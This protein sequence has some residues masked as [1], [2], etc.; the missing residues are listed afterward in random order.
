MKLLTLYLLIVGCALALRFGG[1]QKTIVEVSGNQQ[2]GVVYRVDAA[3]S[4][5]MV[6]AFRSGLLWFKGHDHFIKVGDFTGE[7][8]LTP[9]VINPATL[10]MTIRAD[11]LEETGAAFTPEQKQIIKKELTEI[12]LEPAKYPDIT[13]RST[14]VTG[15]FNGAQFEAKIGGDLGLHGVT[16]RV[17]IPVSVTLEGDNLRAKG[18]FHIKRGDFNVK[19]TSAV[20]GLVRVQQKLKF[21]FD[22]V[23]HKER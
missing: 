16:R 17:V 21:T 13:F 14:D 8:R 12:V 2:P 18:E 4:Q 10:T 20:H 9:N 22:I 1:W 3:Q 23:A 11:S 19:A 6:H 7:A 5:F 15:K